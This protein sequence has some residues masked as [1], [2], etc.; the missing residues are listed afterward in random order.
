MTDI[1]ELQDADAGHVDHGLARHGHVSY[2]EIP[3]DD[4]ER[5]AAF[6]EAAF[7]WQIHRRADGNRSFD[8]RI[9]D[10]I[11]RWVT[12]R[13]PSRESGLLPYIYVDHIDEVVGQVMAH[14]GEIVEQIRPD[15]NLL[16]ATF[17]DPAG[18]LLGIWEDAVARSAH[19]VARY[20]RF[21]DRARNVMQLANQESQRFGRD[22]I[23]TEHILLGLR[24]EEEGVAA[25]CLKGLGADLRK[26]RREIERL[27][28]ERGELSD[29]ARA[30]M[31]R[32]PLTQNAQQLVENAKKEAATLDHSCV[33]TGHLLVGLCGL[34][35]AGVLRII[36]NLGLT[37]ETIRKE[38]FGLLNTKSA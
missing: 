7:G 12:G 29:T 6:Y 23:G 15:G 21:T 25:S 4:R 20:D 36:T 32:M 17:R 5:S 22:H 9:G 13:A 16:V 24:K 33:G 35:D 3:A 8:H 38:V 30:P 31:G 19:E 1:D 2:L 26:I 18:N 28:F 37:P 14:G 11:G 34:K 27:M 10:L